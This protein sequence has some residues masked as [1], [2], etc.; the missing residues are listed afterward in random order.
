MKRFQ[1]LIFDFDGTLA[2]VP[3]DFN[4]MRRKIAALAEG[5]LPERPAVDG[6]PALEF[7][8][9]LT[10]QVE[11]YRNRDEGL[12]FNCRARLAITDMEVRAA[13]KGELFEFTRPAL[14]LLRERNVAVGVISRN[15]TPAVKG[16]F[17]DI[18][19][20]VQIFIPRDKAV[21]VKPHPDHMHQALASMGVAPEDSL[22]VGDHP[23]DVETGVRAGAAAAGV[24]TGNT[25]AAGFQESGALF[26]E[27]HVGRL[28]D[29]L[30]SRQLI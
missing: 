7:V 24:T 14:D 21:R 5:F 6:Q 18:M 27:E 4:L 30:L 10:R 9:E 19:E 8:E 2:R 1:A 29:V 16:V 13:E 20:H 17:P 28:M 22:M 15:I 3:L 26:V 23:M 12:E 25:D 11:K